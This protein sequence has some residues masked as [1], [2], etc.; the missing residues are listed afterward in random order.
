MQREELPDLVTVGSSFELRVIGI[1]EQDASRAVSRVFFYCL[2][3]EPCKVGLTKRTECPN[4]GR[5][6][7]T[8][9]QNNAQRAGC[10]FFQWIDE[11]WAPRN[12]DL[13]MCM[14]KGQ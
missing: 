7:L 6:F 10:N 5:C 11:V 14:S 1:P 3:R 12:T 9:A 4:C 8:C 13:Q 2:C